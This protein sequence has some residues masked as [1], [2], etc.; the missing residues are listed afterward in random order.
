MHENIESS[1]SA[2]DFPSGVAHKSRSLWRNRDYLLLLS[3]QGISLLGSGVS[4]L[5]LPF[6]I[7]AITHSAAQTGYAFALRALPYLV[8]SLPAGALIDRWN[9]KAVMIVCDSGRALALGSI[10]VALVLGHLTITQIYIVA[11]VEGTLFTFFNIAEVACLPRVVAQ[12]Q[13]SAASGYNQVGEGVSLLVGPP[14]GGFL[15]GLSQMLPFVA[16]AISYAVSVISLALI[17]VKFQAERVATQQHLGREIR[18]GLAWLWRQ[19]LVRYMAF[20]T[21]G[22]NFAFGGIILVLILLIKQLLPI[23]QQGQLPFFTGIITAIASIGGIVGALVGA[24]IQRRFTFGQ[25]IIAVLWL[26]AVLWTVQALAPNPYILGVIGA[27]QF[28]LGPIYNVVSV[29][30][31]LALIPDELQ[32]R[33]N[34]SFRLLAFGFQP[35]GAALTGLA[36]QYLSVITTIYLFGGFLFLLALATTVIPT[37][38]RAPPL[39][40]VKA[41]N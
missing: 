26:Q 5:A 16:D 3:G 10:P 18:E 25:V 17:R 19:S 11:L 41:E 1:S 27:G 23:Q 40:Q 36:L 6:L 12:D 15:F 14:L 24:Q 39:S 13:L 4:T 34:S 2:V 7:L 20:L 37:V 8:F 32:G 28:V 31:R 9:R 30:Y 38:R 33:V 22:I 35:L 29:G 21:G